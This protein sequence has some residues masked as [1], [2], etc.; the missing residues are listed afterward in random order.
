MGRNSD[1]EVEEFFDNE[2]SDESAIAE[3]TQTISP[4]DIIEFYNETFVKGH[5]HSYEQ[6]MVTAI[7]SKEEVYI[8]FDAAYFMSPLTEVRILAKLQN[9]G[10]YLPF[11]GS[12][13]LYMKNYN[14]KESKIQMT[15]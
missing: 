4:G 14:F 12:T 13:V 1:N 2:S 9:D 8:S 7:K 15:S 3:V 5:K 6:V 10:T 11:K